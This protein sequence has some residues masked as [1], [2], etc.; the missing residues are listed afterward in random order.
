MIKVGCNYLSLPDMDIETFI[1]TSYELRLDTIDFHRR[2]FASAEP[3]Y[4]L[5]IKMLCLKY[6][7]PI[8]YIGVSTSFIGEE[9][10]LRGEVGQ[11]KEGIGLAAFLGAPL[12]RVFGAYVPAGVTDRSSLWP[13][14]IR[15]LG[16]AAEYGAEKGIIVA[17]QNHDNNNLAATG[18]DVLRILR[19]TNHPNFSFI[20][21]TGQWA[22][23]PGANP[24]RVADP[25]RNIYSDIEETAPH[26]CYVRTKF[27]D[28]STGKEK[29]LDY[30]RI[31]QILKEVG[32]NGNL[33]IVYEGKGDHLE[34]VKK[35]AHYLR[36]LIA[37]YGL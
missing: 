6:G 7:L 36:T 32:Y 33:S 15:C 25:S 26:A 20:L 10:K 14:M 23:S 9:E 13:P 21:D 31:F 35:A 27:Y 24:E 12:I 3:D 5:R 28:I 2:A 17:L 18:E 8:G 34:G 11:A 16:E 30:D 22:G 29:H 1:R 4:L 37:C 19:E